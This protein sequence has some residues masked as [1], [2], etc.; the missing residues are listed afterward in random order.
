VNIYPQETE[1][2]LLEHACVRDAAVFGVPHDEMGEE[3][4][5]LVELT[6]G[7]TGSPDLAAELIDF[8][9][10]RIAHY[11]APRRVDFVAELPRTP[12]GKLLKRE[13]REAYLAGA[14]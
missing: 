10:E 9:R 7:V 6:D 4:V 5:A 14:D 11:K 8:V 3:V 2:A 12:N 13:V 1:N